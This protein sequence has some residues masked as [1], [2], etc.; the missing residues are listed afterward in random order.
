MYNS[1]MVTLRVTQRIVY[2]RVKRAFALDTLYITTWRKRRE[3]RGREMEMEAG[4]TTPENAILQLQS[5]T[6]PPLP[7]AVAAAAAAA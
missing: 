6:C 5:V 2:C 3:R 7:L 1:A 4:E